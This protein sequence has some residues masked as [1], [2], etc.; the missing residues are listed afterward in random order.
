[1]YKT[2]EATRV[3]QNIFWL[4]QVGYK[5]I[6]DRYNVLLLA[7][8]ITISYSPLRELSILDKDTHT[9]HLNISVSFIQ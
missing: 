8:K 5:G 1:M 3:L 2:Y 6:T 9:C 4:V 7:A